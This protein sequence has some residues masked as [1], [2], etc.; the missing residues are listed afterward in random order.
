MRT[1]ALFGAKNF[2]FFEVYGVLARTRGRGVEP[3]HTRREEVFAIL[4]GRPLRTVPN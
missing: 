4:C 3:M 1:S 2:E